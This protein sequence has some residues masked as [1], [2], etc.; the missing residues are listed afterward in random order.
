M[1]VEP[2]LTFAGRCEEAL[3]F[4]RRAID[5]KPQMVM[6]FKEIPEPPQM[7]LPGWSGWTAR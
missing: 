1:R 4:Y 5:A 7:P 6:C 3:A 2:Y